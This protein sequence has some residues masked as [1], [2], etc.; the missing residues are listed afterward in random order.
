[1]FIL[2]Y[3]KIFFVI[4]GLFVSF[5]LAGIFTQ[6]LN[7]GLDFTGGSIVEIQFKDTIPDFDQAQSLIKTDHPDAVVQKIGD[8]S[9]LIRT[10]ELSQ[11]QK[12]E[13]LTS[14]QPLGEFTETRFNTIGPSVGKELRSKSIISII[15]VSLSILVFIAFVFRSVSKPVSSWKYGVVALIALVHDIIIPTGLFAWFHIPVD[16]LF[17][18]G[19]LTI[20]TTSINDTIVTFDRVRENLTKYYHKKT[21]TFT[22]IVGMSIKETITRSIMTSVTIMLALLALFF[23]GPETTKN[24]SLMMLVGMFFGTYS[25]IALAA[26]LLVTW[27]QYLDRKKSTT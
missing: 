7:W 16:T 18:V 23:F 9:Y 4:A 3:K 11:E 24:L 17:V 8:S 25:S 10:Q 21:Y 2:Q 12:D 1:M 26:P 20:L 19:L 14:L 5:A 22:Q 15:L 13:F 27:N 6:G